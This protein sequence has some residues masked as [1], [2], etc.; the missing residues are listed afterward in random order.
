[1]T[2]EAA[3]SSGEVIPEGYCLDRTNEV[4]E[5]DSSKYHRIDVTLSSLPLENPSTEDRK[6]HIAMMKR[7]GRVRKIAKDYG[8]NGGMT[9]LEGC[10]NAQKY[11]NKKDPFKI[12]TIHYNEDE[13][14]FEV[15]IESEGNTYPDNFRK[16]LED[17]QKIAFACYAQVAKACELTESGDH[18]DDENYIGGLGLIEMVGEFDKVEY[19]RSPNG[20]TITRLYIKENKRKLYQNQLIDLVN[21]IKDNIESEE[22]SA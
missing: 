19:Y 4:F 14:G 8:F 12:T 3:I 11:G 6:Y 10:A 5:F 22:K 17:S 20:G 18:A 9:I 1:M 15:L 2:L 21:Q 13:E 7:T 16:L